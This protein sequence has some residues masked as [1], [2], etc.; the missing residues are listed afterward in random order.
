[1][2]TTPSKTSKKALKTYQVAL[3]RAAAVIAAKG[4]GGY[5]VQAAAMTASHAAWIQIP[6][7]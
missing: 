5:P 4:N 3:N 6:P 2:A 1:M 7:R